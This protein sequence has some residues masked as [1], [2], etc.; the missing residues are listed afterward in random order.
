MASARAG[1][2]P[3]KW[4]RASCRDR[5][6][7]AGVPTLS[8]FVI[9]DA[10]P[11]QISAV[12]CRFSSFVSALASNQPAHCRSTAQGVQYFGDVVHPSFELVTI[13]RQFYLLLCVHFFGKNLYQPS[14][15]LNDVRRVGL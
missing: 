12:S 7:C 6:R 11:R 15:L 2:P 13:G 9:Q 10:P 14:V 8:R 3:F 1:S 5:A 4:R